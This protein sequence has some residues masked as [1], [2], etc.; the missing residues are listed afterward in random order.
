M[1]IASQI[2][3]IGSAGALATAAWKS[4]ELLKEIYGDLAKPGVQQVGKAI[5]SVLGLGSTILLPL[6][7]ANEAARQFEVKAFERIARRFSEIPIEQI[8]EVVPDIAIPLL[9]KISIT[10]DENLQ[11]MFIELLAKASNS[12]EVSKAHPSFISI[13]ANMTSDEAFIIKDLQKTNLHPTINVL[14]F[15][16]N[17]GYRV[18]HPL[19]F[20]VPD[21]VVF[22]ENIPFYLTILQSK[23]L[24]QID[25]TQEIA[26]QKLYDDLKSEIDKIYQN[27][28]YR[29][30]RRFHIPGDVVFEKGVIAMTPFGDRFLEACT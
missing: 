16:E 12:D 29:D 6:R 27:A 9:E 7:L 23:G 1:D 21:E 30:F 26:D 2:S 20:E 4:P 28:P 14:R 11:S 25:M 10:S 8:C 19:I 15:S 3:A 17:G 5:S 18:I 13:I 22:L 24:I